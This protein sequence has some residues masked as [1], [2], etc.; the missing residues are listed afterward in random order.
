MPLIYDKATSVSHYGEEK[1]RRRE[2]VLV[3][4][5]KSCSD[6]LG[7]MFRPLSL[8]DNHERKQQRIF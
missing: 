3:D 7:Q 1:T 5:K 8:E 6:N 2:E 4:H